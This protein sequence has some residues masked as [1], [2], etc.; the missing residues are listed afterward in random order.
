MQVQL[1]KKLIDRLVESG[2]EVLTGP[3]QAT[4][5]DDCTFEAPCSIK[6]MRIH[7]SLQMGAYSYAVTGYY[8]AVRMGRYC[9]IGEQVQMG[10]GDHPTNWLSTSPFQYLREPLFNV[11]SGF[12]HAADFKGFTP[13]QR[14]PKTPPPSQVKPIQ[15]GNDVWI[16]HGAMVLPGVTIGDGA[17]I[18]ANAMVTKDVPP[19]AVLV[20]NPGRVVKQ[21]FPDE[22]IADLLELKWWRFAP[23]QMNG[24]AFHDIRSAIARMKDL[25]PDLQA[26]QPPKVSVKELITK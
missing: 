13:P 25:L 19:Y 2:V 15:I 18:G 22:V 12:A 26:Y 3:G 16:G 23:W 5:S 20:G 24:V 11:G 21:R 4:I 1:D 6:W 7:H 14:P 10:R 9:S 17:I 8:F